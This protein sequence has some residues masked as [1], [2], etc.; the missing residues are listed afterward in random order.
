M[1]KFCSKAQNMDIK[2]R[3]LS[4]CNSG[5]LPRH[6][7]IKCRNMLLLNDGRTKTLYLRDSFILNRR[8]KPRSVR[9]EEYY[10]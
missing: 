2:S 7:I 5:L 4:I 3:V 9:E 6:F 1:V 8:N 10:D